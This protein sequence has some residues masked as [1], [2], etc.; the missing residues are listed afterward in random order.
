MMTNKRQQEN[1]IRHVITHIH[2]LFPGLNMQASAQARIVCKRCNLNIRGDKKYSKTLQG[3]KRNAIKGLLE[4][5]SENVWLGPTAHACMR[6]GQPACAAPR[7]WIV[8][9]GITNIINQAAGC[10]IDMPYRI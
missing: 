4:T 9:T 3:T 1:Y 7:D 10:M 8:D 5:R 2:T 6:Q